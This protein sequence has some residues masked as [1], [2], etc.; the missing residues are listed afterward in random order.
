MS[1]RALVTGASGFL[2]RALVPALLAVGESVVAT[3]RKAC[4]FAPHPRLIRRQADLADPA[5]PLAGILRGVD[6]IYHLSWS[7]ILA[8]SNLAPFED[9]RI[10]IVGPCACSKASS[11]EQVR[12]SYSR[13]RAER[14]T[15]GSLKRRRRRSIR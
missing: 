8:D 1:V 4:H 5:A 7:T 6:T 10:N 2:G 13:P 3:G 15:G 9:A 11:V 12:G 14:S